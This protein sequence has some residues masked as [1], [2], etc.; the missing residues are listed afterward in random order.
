MSKLKVGDQILFVSAQCRTSI[1][2]KRSDI[3]PDRH[4]MHKGDVSVVTSVNGR[5]FAT[6][7]DKTEIMWEDAVEVITAHPVKV[8]CKSTRGG[9][10]ERQ[11]ALYR[12]AAAHIKSRTSA[13]RAT[14]DEFEGN[15]YICHTFTLIADKLGVNVSEVKDRFIADLGLPEGAH[16]EPFLCH[17]AERFNDG[18]VPSVD[19]LPASNQEAN[20]G[21]VRLLLDLASKRKDRKEAAQQYAMKMSRIW[22][23]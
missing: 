9:P 18:L 17:F 4:T 12:A 11:R 2:G 6:H 3:E 14:P 21:R 13:K 19:G 16:H 7:H 1:L 22:L 5:L 20:D 23:A 10:T 8:K 15:Y